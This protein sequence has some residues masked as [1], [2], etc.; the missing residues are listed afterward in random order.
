M[1]EIIA[2]LALAFLLTSCG[3]PP[4]DERVAG[5]APAL[6]AEHCVLAHALATTG[7]PTAIWI[8]AAVCARP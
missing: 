4:E 7:W 3:P 6:V 1:R 5:H 2:S 8:D